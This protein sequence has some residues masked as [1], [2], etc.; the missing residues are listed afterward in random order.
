MFIIQ[1][2]GKGILFVQHCLHDTS[3]PERPRTYWTMSLRRPGNALG[4][5]SCQKS[6]RRQTG[7]SGHNRSL[8]QVQL[9]LSVVQAWVKRQKMDGQ[10]TQGKWTF[11]CVPWQ[12]TDRYA[13]A[14][15]SD[16]QL[17]TRTDSLVLPDIYQQALTRSCRILQKHAKKT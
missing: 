11:H 14:Q 12:Q 5:G 17:L 10:V 4:L 8:G 7:Q 3:H 9:R 13:A 1:G 16:H 2:E 6:W 15:I